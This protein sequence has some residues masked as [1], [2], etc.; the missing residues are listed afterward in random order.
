M[1]CKLPDRLHA[2]LGRAPPPPR[3]GN[4]CGEV[5]SSGGQMIASWRHRTSRP[6]LRQQ[7]FLHQAVQRLEACSHRRLQCVLRAT[8]TRLMIAPRSA[9]EGSI[10]W[11]AGCARGT[12]R[13]CM[14]RP[15]PPEPS[16][17]PNKP[18]HPAFCKVWPSC[19]GK[20]LPLHRFQ[21]LP[22]LPLISSPPLPT[23]NRGAYTTDLTVRVRATSSVNVSEWGE[24]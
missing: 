14:Q 13:T 24:R 20:V 8:S 9:A 19:R 2:S 22:P 12:A 16:I 10:R 4:A 5:P 15:T 6:V 23:S 3:R 17:P 21:Y 7:P 1:P 18:P 11:W